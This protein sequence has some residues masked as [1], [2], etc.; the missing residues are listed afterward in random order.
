M[1][2][3]ICLKEKALT[4]RT[5]PGLIIDVNNFI[6]STGTSCVLLTQIEI[7]KMDVILLKLKVTTSVMNISPDENI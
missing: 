3:N 7:K 2:D 5:N 4:V 1:S 6:I